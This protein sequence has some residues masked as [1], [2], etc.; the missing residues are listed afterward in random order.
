[1]GS[2]ERYLAFH[3]ACWEDRQLASRMLQDDPSLLDVRSGLL[4]TV[5]HDSAIENNPD[6]VR[7]LLG[8]GADPNA[9][10]FSEN[11]AIAECASICCT[12]YDLCEVIDLLLR[13]G[14]DPYLYSELVPCAWHSAAKSSFEPLRSLFGSIPPPR[15]HH[16]DCEFYLGLLA[17]SA[18]QSP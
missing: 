17:W 8:A 4:E 12:D 16:S 7:F 18:K 9:R 1:M 6:V 5:L 10:N 13:A 3:A 11:S 2:S 15:D 14:A